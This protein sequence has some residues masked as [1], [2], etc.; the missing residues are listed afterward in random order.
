MPKA[1]DEKLYAVRTRKILLISNAIA[2]T[3]NIIA[4]GI[5]TGVGVV[6]ENPELVKKAIDYLD[7]GGL[8]VTITRLFTDIRFIMKVKEEFINYRLDQQLIETLDNLDRYLC[9]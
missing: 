7:V 6:G 2:S 4:V 9:T 1:E 5:A 8:I 3:S